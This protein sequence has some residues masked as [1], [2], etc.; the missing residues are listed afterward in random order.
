M[1]MILTACAQVDQSAG[2]GGSPDPRWDSFRQRATQVAQAWQ[3]GPQQQD[4]RT[5]YIPLQDPTVLPADPKFSSE[6]KE[7]FV[8]GWYRQ[9]AKLPTDKPD[10]GSIRFPDG[11][12]S[13]P[14]LS[15][16]D[17]YRQ[18]DH[19]D[20]PPCA[21]RP[22]APPANSAGP[23][24]S[25]SS[26]P[27]TVCIPLTV[28]A[29]RLGTVKVRTSRGEAQVP[30]WLFTV[31]E[32]SAPVAR[33][34]VAE[35]AITPVPAP[36]ALDR[37]QRGEYVAAQDLVTIEGT[38]LTYRLGVGACD[39]DLTPLVEQRDDL[40]VVGGAVTRSPGICTDQL[41]AKPVT[42]TLDAPLG[43]RPVLDAVNGQ[44]LLLGNA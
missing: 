23:D 14:L 13:V 44:P 17:A 43:A 15:A 32:L 9:Q 26:G 6:T 7:A 8:A 38:K 39:Q 21:G 5:K 25:V 10:D 34:A 11:T 40:V 29:A 35:S 19:G 27:S 30:A 4:W 28:T 3:N 18:I 31:D 16:A 36:P 24:G 12:L 22:A 42:V 1:I 2:P 37:P 33:L 41:I 20:P